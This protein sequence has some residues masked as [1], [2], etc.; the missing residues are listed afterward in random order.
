MSFHIHSRHSDVLASKRGYRMCIIMGRSFY[1]GSCLLSEI[2]DRYLIA[3]IRRVV[4]K[5]FQRSSK[6][7][8]V[9]LNYTVLSRMCTTVISLLECWRSYWYCSITALPSS[10]SSLILKTL[11]YTYFWPRPLD[12]SIVD[13][14]S[15]TGSLLSMLF[16]VL[17]RIMLTAINGVMRFRLRLHNWV[18]WP[19]SQ[20]AWPNRL[21][22]PDSSL[23]CLPRLIRYYTYSSKSQK[24]YHTCTWGKLHEG[25]TTKQCRFHVQSPYERGHRPDKFVGA[26][27]SRSRVHGLKILDICYGAYADKCY[28]GCSFDNV[29]RQ[30]HTGASGRIAIL[31]A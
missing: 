3:D 18:V 16:H 27:Y 29:A 28:S 14:E 19:Q 23:H 13:E 15:N 25:G 8:N 31:F 1:L 10:F 17:D 11:Q 21:I 24:W 7:R 20:Q 26:F 2:H 12:E 5:Q 6:S 30:R 9:L 22:S 4:I